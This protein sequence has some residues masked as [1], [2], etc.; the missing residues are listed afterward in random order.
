MKR[1][2]K[3][4][5]VTNSSKVKKI[6]NCLPVYKEK[7]EFDNPK[8]MDEAV[9]KARWC[10]VNKGE[11]KG[12][13]HKPAYLKNFGRDHQRKKFNKP[14][15]IQTAQSQVGSKQIDGDNKK[16]GTVKMREPLKF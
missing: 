10:W 8:T 5:Y 1:W 11:F 12:K 16:E 13:K 6:L 15:E 4:D 14:K 3:L 7:I 9:R 2:E